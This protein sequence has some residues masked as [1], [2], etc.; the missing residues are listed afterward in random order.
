MGNRNYRMFVADVVAV[1]GMSLVQLA[2]N[3]ALLS[4]MHK[5]EF[6]KGLRDFYKIEESN[7]KA[8]GYALLSVCTVIVVVMIGFTVELLVLHYWLNKNGITTFDYIVY[9]RNHPNEAVDVEKIRN[10]HASRVLKKLGS[11]SVAPFPDGNDGKN[12]SALATQGAAGPSDSPATASK[13]CL[14]ELEAG[15]DKEEMGRDEATGE[16]V[17]CAASVAAEAKYRVGR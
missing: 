11:R 13:R 10:M 16:Q 7:A 9:T 3:I 6:N 14:E 5:E 4:T 12:T 15:E 1:L 2:A 8:M 17:C